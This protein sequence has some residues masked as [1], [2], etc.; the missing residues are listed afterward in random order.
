MFRP[1][2]LALLVVYAS[3]VGFAQSRSGP[4]SPDTIQPISRGEYAGDQACAGCHRDKAQAY[5][6][7]AHFLSSTQVDAGALAGKLT[8]PSVTLKTGNPRVS[9]RIDT[10]A[11]GYFQT[12]TIDGPPAPQVTTARIDLATGSGRKGNTYLSWQKDAL[13]QLPVSYWT[14]PGRWINSPGFVDGRADFTRSI[15]PRCLECHATYARPVAPPNR[16]VRDETILGIT[17]EKCHGPGRDHVGHRGPAKS[18][19]IDT[20]INPKRLTRERQIELC[21]T[22]HAGTALQSRTRPFTYRPG[23]PLTTYYTR[24]PASR[25][26]V[27]EVHANQIA[28]LARS[29][30]FEGSQMTCSTCHDVHATERSVAALSTRCLTCHKA[31]AH[32][33]VPNAPANLRAGCVDCHMPN[34]KSN[35]LVLTTLGGGS[36]LQPQVRTH[37]IKVY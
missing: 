6:K 37:W 23:R 16:Y 5:R 27:V 11:N 10:R 24:P 31:E 29:E 26:P 28:L 35:A 4:P 33:P 32:K 14:T 15:T 25:D 2:A 12:G 7:T 21:E 8:Q 18:P 1:A 36:T 34:Q 9:F 20:I 19:S 22:C 13:Y 3:A 30:C 17:C